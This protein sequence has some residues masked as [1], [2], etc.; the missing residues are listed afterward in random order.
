MLD[1]TRD[2]PPKWVDARRTTCAPRS[3]D[4]CS[5]AERM[6]RWVLGLVV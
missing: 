1:L 4:A 6:P 3:T 5:V 2:P